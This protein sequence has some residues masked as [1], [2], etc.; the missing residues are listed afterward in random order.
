[1]AVTDE[2]PFKGNEHVRLLW[3][4]LE[5]A[6]DHT[7]LRSLLTDK[8]IE[9]PRLKLADPVLPTTTLMP[10]GEDVI[11][12]PLRPVAVP[13][14]VAVCGGGGG[15]GPGGSIVRVIVLVTPPAVAVI[16]TAVV[17]VTAL[18]AI[19]KVADCDPWGT[20]T[21]AGTVAAA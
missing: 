18:V 8:V 13:V 5:E 9:A 19:G 15:G 16:V 1:L 2:L 7:A 21:L 12:C 17:V 11:R 14:R 3:P 4:P 20:V 10:A 6:P